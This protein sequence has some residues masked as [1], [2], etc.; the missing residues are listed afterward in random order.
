M[1]FRFLKQTPPQDCEILLLTMNLRC[2]KALHDLSFEHL[3]QLPGMHIAEAG[4]SH[5]CLIGHNAVSLQ[6][7][8]LF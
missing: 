6:L 1:A 7:G 2:R 8:I 3:C 5:I 4:L